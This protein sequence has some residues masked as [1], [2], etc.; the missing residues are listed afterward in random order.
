V[1]IWFLCNRQ[2]A[3]HAKDILESPRKNLGVIV[4]ILGSFCDLTVKNIFDHSETSSIE[5]PVGYAE[6]KNRRT[7]RTCG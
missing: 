4:K 5:L 1:F 6:S 3:K 7:E 2:D